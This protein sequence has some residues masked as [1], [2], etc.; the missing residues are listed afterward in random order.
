[1]KKASMKVCIDFISD[2]I[3]GDMFR[4]STSIKGLQNVTISRIEKH[5]HDEYILY[6][7][8]EGL[9]DYCSDDET[10]LISMQIF[11]SEFGVLEWKF[12]DKAVQQNP[13]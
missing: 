11:R 12:R 2:M 3:F 9:P 4:N 8:G 6:L 10:L 5:Q 1:M 13:F 7:Y